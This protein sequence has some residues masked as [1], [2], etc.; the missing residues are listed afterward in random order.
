MGSLVIK[1]TMHLVQTSAEGTARLDLGM[2]DQW[3]KH[4]PLT[5]YTDSIQEWVACVMTNQNIDLALCTHMDGR[6]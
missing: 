3:C 1:D 6:I 2:F 4:K 5:R